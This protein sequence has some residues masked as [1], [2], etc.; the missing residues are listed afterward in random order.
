MG[1]KVAAPLVEA[2]LHSFCYYVD[3]KEILCLCKT[4]RRCHDFV[5]FDT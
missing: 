1:E 4:I 3:V 2:L 5:T